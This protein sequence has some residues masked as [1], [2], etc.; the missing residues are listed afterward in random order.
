MSLFSKISS[1]A[2]D[3][4]P[5]KAQQ[6]PNRFTQ[7][8]F[9]SM[10]AATHPARIN[11]NAE[12]IGSLKII[13][14]KEQNK[15]K[16]LVKSLQEQAKALNLDLDKA[17]PDNICDIAEK[18]FQENAK[19][20]NQIG[21]FRRFTDEEAREVDKLNNFNHTLKG[22]KAAKLKAA[23]ITTFLQQAGDMP[24]RHLSLAHDIVDLSN[25]SAFINHSIFPT[26]DFNVLLRNSQTN[27]FSTL[28]GAILDVL[29]KLSK[30]N[31]QAVDLAETVTSN[32]DDSVA[33]FFL[34]KF[35]DR[36]PLAPE[37]AKLTEGFVPRIAGSVLKGM[38]SMDLGENCKES[39][40]ESLVRC[41]AS[42]DSK[43]ENLK[44]LNEVFKMTDK[45]PDN[46]KTHFNLCEIRLGD[47]EAIKQN[48]DV[49][50]QLLGNA[51]AQG[52]K[53]LDITGFLTKNIN[54][55]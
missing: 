47:T 38:P 41:L 53:Q 22:A 31:P 16:Q 29:P 33:R 42:P 10:G 17:N 2:S 46:I 51:E 40:F 39:L 20:Y 25:T 49:L 48:V 34:N 3:I 35:L 55:D 4:I 28:M 21:Q 11:S 1:K 50:P 44:I 54:L 12:I 14:Q 32:V 26:I 15:H 30:E 13:A 27:R 9:M 24:Q 52:V 23:E 6:L 36:P 37:Q 8:G 45:L 19:K 43:P 7:G 5:Q 18:F